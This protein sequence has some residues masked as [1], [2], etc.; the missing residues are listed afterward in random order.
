MDVVLRTI[1]VYVFLLAVLRLA[2]KRTLSEMST[3]DFVLVLIV[4]EATQNALIVDD[5][6]LSNGLAVVLALVAMDRL[7]SG[8]KRR[9]PRLEKVVDGTP[10]TLV[11]H[12]RVLQ[13]RLD[14]SRVTLDDVLQAARHTRGLRRLEQIRYAV[15][16]PS[17][18]ISVIPMEDLDE[19][20]RRIEQAVLRA[21][22]GNEAS[23]RR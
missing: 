10:L 3:F 15:L 1:A 4:S 8:L 14:A 13:E 21:L 23:G 12:G 6:S 16:E 20:D 5:H 11:D 18:G 2:G 7:A 17:G 19:I 22:S 9:F